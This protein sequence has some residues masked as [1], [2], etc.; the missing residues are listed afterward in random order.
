MADLNRMFMGGVSGF[1]ES[2][3]T[4][5]AKGLEQL[6]QH[7]M[8]QSDP[9]AIRLHYD[10]HTAIRA[11]LFPTFG[12]LPY[13]TDYTCPNAIGGSCGNAL[14]SYNGALNDVYNNIDNSEY[15]EDKHIAEAVQ[16]RNNFNLQE[17][18]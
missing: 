15:I 10:L 12:L 3:E 14:R 4:A 2:A 1:A 13:K 11:S 17:K 8:Q 6:V 9:Q 16:Y 7:F 18:I 5:R